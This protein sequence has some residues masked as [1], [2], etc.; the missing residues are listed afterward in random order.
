MQLQFPNFSTK[1]HLSCFPQINPPPLQPIQSISN[2]L[3]FPI[4]RDYPVVPQNAPSVRSLQVFLI[5]ADCGR[6][7]SAIFSLP[8]ELRGTHSIPPITDRPE[9][10]MLT[11]GKMGT[12]TWPARGVYVT[13]FSFCVRFLL[14][15]SDIWI[16]AST[17]FWIFI[18]KSLYSNYHCWEGVWVTVHVCGFTVN[19]GDDLNWHYQHVCFW[20][21]LLS[22]WNANHVVLTK[23]VSCTRITNSFF[24]LIFRLR[25]GSLA[26]WDEGYATDNPH[27]RS[28]WNKAHVQLHVLNCASIA[29]SFSLLTWA[30]F[31]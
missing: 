8:E 30:S 2:F 5:A 17:S 27:D 9:V 16:A 24:V 14:R 1:V 3:Q 20:S 6:W 15:F 29:Q 10:V 11:Q 21:L 28:L 19:W 31:D 26:H 18:S 13:Q 4:Q 7:I 25:H 22:M 23:D 12:V